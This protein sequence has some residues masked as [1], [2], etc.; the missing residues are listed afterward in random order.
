MGKGK[1]KEGRQEGREGGKEGRMEEQ[2]L[3]KRNFGLE[4]WVTVLSAEGL[5]SVLSIHSG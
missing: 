2:R 1:R 3:I 4:R 5:S